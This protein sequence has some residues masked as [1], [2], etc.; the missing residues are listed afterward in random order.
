MRWTG[1]DIVPGDFVYRWRKAKR[2][3]DREKLSAKLQL[4]YDGPWVVSALIGSRV[5]LHHVHGAQD[6]VVEDRLLLRVMPAEA[7][8]KDSEYRRGDQIRI[9]E[10]LAVVVRAHPGRRITVLWKDPTGGTQSPYEVVHLDAEPHVRADDVDELRS[11]DAITGHEALLTRCIALK[12]DDFILASEEP[13]V[14]GGLTVLTMRVG[15]VLS[16]DADAGSVEVVLYD[17]PNPSAPVLDR[18]FRPLHSATDGRIYCAKRGEDGL[19]QGERTTL[20]LANFAFEQ[21][22][23][24]PFSLCDDRLPTLLAKGLFSP[25]VTAPTKEPGDLASTQR[26]AS[27]GTRGGPLPGCVPSCPAYGGAHRPHTCARATACE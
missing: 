15:R 23:Y 13:E 21:L 14:T 18:L 3:V 8:A 2:E 7:A 25:R 10:K 16:V 22:Y 24:G 26:G 12:E 1:T 27:G 20:V 9:R 6:D 19:L 17:C 11:V 4:S 5:R